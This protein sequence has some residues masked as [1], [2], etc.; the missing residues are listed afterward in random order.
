MFYK[1]IS[2][3]SIAPLMLLSSLSYAQSWTLESSV[4]QAMSVSPEIKK[5]IA[6]LGARQDDITLS[7]MWPDPGIEF[8]VD[9]KLGQDDGSGGY[10][11]TDITISQAIPLSRTG[12][13]QSVAE[14]R[15]KSSQY[16]QQYQALLLQNRVSRVF[17]QLQFASAELHLAEKRLQLADKQTRQDRRNVNGAIVRYITPLEKMRMNI[18]R[19]EA[20]QAVSSAEGKYNEALS[21]FVKL[22]GIDINSKINVLD[23]SP[24]KTIPNLDQLLSQQDQ[25]VQ[26]SEQQQQLVA[27]NHQ[28]NVARKS[29]LDDPTI[30]LSKS[31]DTFDNGRDDVYGLMFNIQIPIQNRKSTAVSKATYEASQQRIELQRLKIELQIN[32]QRSYMHLNHVVEQAVDYQ[33]RV[34]IPANKM[35][36]LTTNGFNSGEL[37]ILSLVDAHSTHFDAQLRYLDLLHQAWVE[38]ADVNLYAG[39]LITDVD[40]QTA[41]STQGVL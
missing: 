17:H 3:L 22:L 19:E 4:K 8:R 13:Q 9:N 21:E 25:H 37:N 26:L 40:L 38:L 18:I 27:A 33:K 36:E 10:D 20:S 12:Y 32:L 35:L 28:I 7:G 16:S 1:I 34:L 39:Q 11:L 30:S 15:Y 41:Y 23:I 6:E 2:A 29:Q 5:S 31:R 14:A 24:L